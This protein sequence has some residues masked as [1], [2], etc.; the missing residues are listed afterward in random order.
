MG[1]AVTLD[2]AQKDYMESIYMESKILATPRSIGRQLNF[3]AGAGSAVSTRL[4][5]AHGLTLAQWAVLSSLWRNGALSIKDLA[6]LTGNASPATSRIV[7]RM[8]AED[9]VVRRPDVSDRRAVVIGLSEKGEQLRRVQDLY[10][11]VNSILMSDLSSAE[12]ETLFELLERVE[13]A[14]RSWLADNR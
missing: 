5:E 14:G 6:K 2:Y 1:P 3:A 13:H 4:L 11:K 9:L 8:I 10:K 7:D 12:Q